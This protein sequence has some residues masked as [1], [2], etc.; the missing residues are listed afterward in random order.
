MV[1]R[2]VVV[3]GGGLEQFFAPRYFDTKGE[4]VE[5]FNLVRAGLKDPDNVQLMQLVPVYLGEFVPRD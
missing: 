4:A 5:E 1:K 3:F 2:F